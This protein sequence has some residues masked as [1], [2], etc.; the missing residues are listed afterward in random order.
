MGFPASVGV[1]FSVAVLCGDPVSRFSSQ[2]SNSMGVGL[3]GS[4]EKGRARKNEVCWC[5]WIGSSVR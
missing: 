2:M 5:V 3:L 1:Y 4:V